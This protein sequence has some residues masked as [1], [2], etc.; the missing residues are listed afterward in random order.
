[1]E[2]KVLATRQRLAGGLGNMVYGRLGSPIVE[3]GYTKKNNRGARQTAD[4][5]PSKSRLK[6]SVYKN[7]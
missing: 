5:N 4:F 6:T 2:R 3:Y 1:M 7:M